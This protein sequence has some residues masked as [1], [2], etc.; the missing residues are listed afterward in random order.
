MAVVGRGITIKRWGVRRGGLGGACA[1]DVWPCLESAG[2]VWVKNCWDEATPHAASGQSL[3]FE[4]TS[5][6]LEAWTPLGPFFLSFLF[7]FLFLC[8][9]PTSNIFKDPLWNRRSRTEYSYNLQSYSSLRSTQSN[10]L[11]L[12]FQT[13]QRQTEMKGD[14]IT[15][16]MFIDM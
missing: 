16:V 4:I 13:R 15:R 9:S 1:C 2:Q 5:N 11:T 8:L 14:R 12:D 3:V 10:F 7:F 6:C